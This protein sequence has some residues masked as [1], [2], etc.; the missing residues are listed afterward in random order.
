MTITMLTPNRVVGTAR[1]SDWA[2]HAPALRHPW[3][4]ECLERHLSGEWGDIDRE[5]TAVNNRARRT[6]SGRELSVYPIPERIDPSDAPDARV[7]IITDRYDTGPVV[8][9]LWPSDY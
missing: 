8:T 3:L 1:L 7:W 4:L 6:G 9:L 5:D 2:N